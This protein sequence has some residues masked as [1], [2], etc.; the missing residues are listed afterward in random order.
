MKDIRN[1]IVEELWRNVQDY[2]EVGSILEIR[3]N[4]RE[5][6]VEFVEAIDRDILNSM[7]HGDEYAASR[8]Y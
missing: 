7:L 2:R 4:I 6:A 5:T 8:T 3:E 1:S